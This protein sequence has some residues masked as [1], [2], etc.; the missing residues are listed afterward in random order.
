MDT[1]TDRMLTRDDL[2]ALDADDPLARFR[3]A[4]VLPRG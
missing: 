4:F 3:D 2:A 1:S